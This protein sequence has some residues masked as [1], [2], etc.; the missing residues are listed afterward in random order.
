[1]TQ[2]PEV[3]VALLLRLEHAVAEILAAPHSDGLALAAIGQALGWQAGTLWQ[4][5]DDRLHCS[6]TWAA[7]GFD[8]GPFEAATRG[9]ALSRGEGLPGAVWHSREPAWVREFGREAS[10]PRAHAAARAGLEAAFCFPLLS[11]GDAVE[12][13]VEFFTGRLDDPPAELLGTARSLGR[14]IGGA[15]ERAR[16]ADAVGRSEARLRAVL[17]SALDC[18]V[19]ADADGMVLEFNPAAC[20]TF[21]YARHEAVGRELAELIIPPQLRDTHREGLRRYL[22]THHPRVLDQRVETTGMRSDGTQFPVELTI[23]RVLGGG[24]PV[25]SG[26]LRDLSAQ[27]AAD[28]ELRASR[29]R[30]MEAAA[31][32]RQRLERDLHDGAQQRLVGLGLTLA[33]A[34]TALPD[35]PARASAILDDA[36]AAL[37]E[38]AIELRNLA[39][40]IHPSSLTRY[41][42]DA[43]LADLGRRAPVELRVAPW[44]QRRFPAAV[45]AAAYFVVSEALTNVARYAGTDVAEVS[46]AV[47]DGVLVIAIADAGGG[48]ADARLGTG[49]RG[50]ADR[51]AMLDGSLEVHSPAGQGTVVRARIPV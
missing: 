42:L 7:P 26:Y 3:D 29:R 1:M 10:F 36:I 2:R 14:R 18:V 17:D 31:V 15:L 9:L 38:A 8:G 41:G 19:I 34:R 44:Q 49:L 48:G 6:A 28:E 13:I 11:A 4:V 21:G 39:R 20:R 27:H 30:T 43:A 12:G 32:E 22:H 24:A 23:T 35:E 40:G 46:L 51:V 50:L 45:E 16:A 25:F 47:E 33:R 37:E 5:H